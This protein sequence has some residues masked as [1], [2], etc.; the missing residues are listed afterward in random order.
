MSKI[1]KSPLR[2]K[3]AKKH[4]FVDKI[5]SIQLILDSLNGSDKKSLI[6]ELNSENLKEKLQQFPFLRQESY[7]K[8]SSS[9]DLNYSGYIAVHA[10]LNN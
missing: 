3:L 10:L 6:N 9:K 1:R 2:S 5:E 8:K 4:N 7:S